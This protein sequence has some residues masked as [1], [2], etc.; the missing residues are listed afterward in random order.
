MGGGRRREEGSQVKDERKSH[1]SRQGNSE[2]Q[3]EES[4]RRGLKIRNDED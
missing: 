4:K 1:G 3:T 2:S